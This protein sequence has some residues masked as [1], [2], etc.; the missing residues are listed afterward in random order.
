MRIKPLPSQKT[1]LRI[2]CCS[3]DGTLTWKDR[4]DR[5][6]N[7]ASCVVGKPA[8][9]MNDR[10]YIIIDL[11]G[12]YFSAHRIV[13][14]MKTGRDS[15]DKLINHRDKKM[16]V[17]R[18]DNLRLATHSNRLQK[19]EHPIGQYDWVSRSFPSEGKI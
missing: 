19:R 18:P 10:G 6:A 14:K 3:E 4:P 1:L 11:D 9:W 16:A 7:V 8:G 12:E 2:F 5:P 13:W 17:N 15:G